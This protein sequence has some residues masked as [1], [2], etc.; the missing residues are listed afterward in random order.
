M[1]EAKAKKV[2]KPQPEEEYIRQRDEFKQ[3]GPTINTDGWLENDWNAL[4]PERKVDRVRMLHACERAYFLRDW[5]KC[6]ELIQRTEELLGVS[7]RAIQDATALLE[8]KKVRKSAKV[9]RHIVELINIKERVLKRM[10]Q[11]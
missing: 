11:E 8:F 2:R 6:L 7:E 5:G 3:V 9:E 4:D 1:S 10:E